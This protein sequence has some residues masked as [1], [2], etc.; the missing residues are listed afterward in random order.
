MQSLSKEDYTWLIKYILCLFSHSSHRTMDLPS[1]SCSL[2]FICGNN[3]F[4]KRKDDGGKTVKVCK[5]PRALSGPGESV[6]WDRRAWRGWQGRIM[7][8]LQKRMRLIP[9]K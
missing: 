3:I 5:G 4:A 9:V 6:G 2:V 8:N 1:L 7:A